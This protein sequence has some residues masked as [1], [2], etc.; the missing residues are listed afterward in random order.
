MKRLA[1]V[2]FSLLVGLAQVAAAE[3]L[4]GRKPNIVFL[5]T[6]DQGYGDISAHG[7][8]VLKTPNLDRLHDEGVRFTDFH[9]SPTCS[10]TRSSLMSGKHEFK[11]GVSHTILERERMSLKTV[12]LPQILKTAGYTTGIF[13]KWHLG[14]EAEYQP[15]RRGFD[16]V[17]IH[18]TGGIGQAFANCSSGDAPGNKYFNPAILHNGKFEQTEGYCT[19]V[20]FNQAEKWID[21]V[22]GKQPFFCY[23][24]TNAPHSPYICLKKDLARYADKV[25]DPQAAHF[26]GMVANIDDNVGRLLTKLKQWDLERD[27]LF[28]FMNDNGGTAG[29]KV[30]N[31]GMHGQK[32]T[33]YRG[34]TRASSFWRWP[35]TLK[36]ADCERLA[37]HIDIFPTLAE[38]AGA[39]VPGEVQKQFDGRSLTSLLVEPQAKWDS[40]I[41]FTHVGRWP[42]GADANDYK[43]ANCSVRNPQFNMVSSGGKAGDQVAKSWVLYDLKADPGETVDVASAHP[44]VMKELQQAYDAWWATVEPL[45]IENNDY[46]EAKENPF[47]VWYEQQYGAGARVPNVADAPVSEAAGPKKPTGK[48]AQPARKGAAAEKKEPAKK[49]AA[50]KPAKA[51]PNAPGEIDPNPAFA[52]VTDDPKLP[53]VLLIGDSISI[54]YTVDVQ[55]LLAGKA[56]VHRIPTNGGPT[57]NGIKNIKAWLGEKKWDVIHFNWG[58]HDVKYMADG[59]RQVELADYEKN[60]RTLIPQMQS[61]GKTVIWCT[62]TPV[63]AG[64]LNPLRK[65]EDV[66]VYNQ[67][68]AK[69][70]AEFKLPVDD[71]YTF[72]SERLEKIQLPANVHFTPTG[73][74]VLA[75]QV[76]AVIEKHLPKK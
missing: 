50:K 60:L 66:P 23:I 76:S 28:V 67:I 42:K 27:T 38:I 57:I 65:T 61:A 36:P 14:D 33:P 34:G 39:K 9:V 72:A 46:Q 10:P 7:N 53:R 58:L 69:V 19:D 12:T 24:A 43:F 1:L 68:A 47:K 71:L 30:F 18:G 8:P 6:D 73:S 70:A 17:F 4:A 15:G 21:S 20:F 40:R 75:E 62:T 49:P 3:S 35:G 2:A 25:D 56:N 29:C 31:A 16:E 63:P 48:Q 32:G 13:G 51:D 41:L 52:P 26:L 64:T 11:N 37:A 45:T 5:I 44:E 55:K 54:G 59:T 22:R 74:E